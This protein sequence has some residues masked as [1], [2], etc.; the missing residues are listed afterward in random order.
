LPITSR[1]V[2]SGSNA[3]SRKTGSR[4][5]YQKVVATREIS[6]SCWTAE[7]PPPT[8]ATRSPAKRFADT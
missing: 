8:T 5:V 1:P 3:P 7:I 4:R 6:S 2:T